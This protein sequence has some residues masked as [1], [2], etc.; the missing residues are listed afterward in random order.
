MSL[1][2]LVKGWLGETQGTLAHLLFLDV[3][4]NA[5]RMLIRPR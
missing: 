5:D 4:I 2:A 1:R 3:Q